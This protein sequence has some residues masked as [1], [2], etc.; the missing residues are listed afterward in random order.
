MAD[1]H[2]LAGASAS[3]SSPSSSTIEWVHQCDCDYAR[4][5]VGA[6]PCTIAIDCEM[7]EAEGS[8][9]SGGAGVAAAAGASDLLARVSVVGCDGATRMNCYV[10]PPDGA[11]ITDYRTAVSGI[12]ACHLQRA[13]A[14]SQSEVQ[15]QLRSMFDGRARVVGHSPRYDFAALGMEPPASAVRD[16]AECPLLSIKQHTRGLRALAVDVLAMD[17]FQAPGQPHDSIDDARAAMQLY[18]YVKRRWEPIIAAEEQEA[19]AAAADPLAN[20]EPDDADGPAP[21]QFRICSPLVN[22][23]LDYQLADFFKAPRLDQLPAVVDSFEGADHYGAVFRPL[24]VEEQRSSTRRILE[25]V[26]FRSEVAEAAA[27]A[28]VQPV[29]LSIVKF[30]AKEGRGVFRIQPK[31][32][33][34]FLPRMLALM[35]AAQHAD[36][37]IDDLRRCIGV[38]PAL[39]DFSSFPAHVLIL[40]DGEVQTGDRYRK[41]HGLPLL[42][43]N[44]T[45][46]NFRVDSDHAESFFPSIL[47]EGV[48]FGVLPLSSIVPQMRA[49]EA[50]AALADDANTPSCCWPH[51]L[52]GKMEE[53]AAERAEA[54]AARPLEQDAELAQFAATVPLNESQ[55]AALRASASMTDEQSIL[56]LQGPP[57]T[58]QFKASAQLQARRT[59][60]RSECWRGDAHSCC[61]FVCLYICP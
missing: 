8:S 22:I 31:D 14:L 32:R 26:A 58:G 39:P 24:I 42:N 47:D 38:A 16:T 30:D 10:R 7:V 44:E 35:M 34:S 37:L 4:G 51:I 59:L 20:A 25:V 29:R 60:F 5:A 12:E 19:A 41:R 61:S 50:I 46:I 3:A 2:A 1:A 21:R 13:D 17:R 11:V 49:D 43:R 27:A 9:S 36:T 45:L 6:W 40:V 54:A 53:G 23:V 28:R 15:D 48:M 55:T 18:L 56:L 52:R 57:G 33:A